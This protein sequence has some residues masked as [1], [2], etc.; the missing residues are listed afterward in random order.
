MVR[1]L[2]LLLGFLAL[3]LGI[4]GAFLPLLP[5]VPFVILAAFLFS[6]GSRR[7]E[8]WL[9]GH[10]QLGPPIR[11]WRE[12]RSISSKG[13][14][15]AYAAFAFSGLLGFLLLPMPWLLVPAL[16]AL[17]G[18]SWIHHRPDAPVRATG[19]HGGPA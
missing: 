3:A 13:K 2:Y 18:G 9:L 8:R 14:R 4:V 17:V 19:E 11:D 6:K 16:A 1:G 10:P 7:W 15:S 5:T 12:S